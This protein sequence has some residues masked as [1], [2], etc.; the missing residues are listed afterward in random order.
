MGCG[1]SDLQ[2][3]YRVKPTDTS[4]TKSQHL[5]IQV[6]EHVNPICIIQNTNVP[7]DQTTTTTDVQQQLNVFA[8]PV[9]LSPSTALASR[10]LTQTVDSPSIMSNRRNSI[11]TKLG[12]T[13]RDKYIFLQ[14]KSLGRGHFG[15]VRRIQA[16]DTGLLY[17]CKIIEKKDLIKSTSV[18][19]REVSIL[20]TVKD[21]P[22]IV[23]LVD[24]FEDERY[25]Y[26]VM[27]LCDGGDLFSK[28]AQQGKYTEVEAAEA[29]RQLA[30]AIHYIHNAGVVHRDIKP[31]NILLTASGQIKLADF[32]LSKVLRPQQ[33]FQM[34]TLCGT[35][36][37]SAR[38]VILRKPY[39]IKV[40]NWSLGVLMYIL[41]GGYHPFDPYG[42]LEEPELLHRIVNGHFDFRDAVWQNV[43][44]EAKMLIMK[45][46][47]PEPMQ[48]MTLEE[49]LSSRWIVEMGKMSKTQQQQQQHHV[50]QQ[51]QQ[52]DGQ[53]PELNHVQ[54]GLQRYRVAGKQFRILVYTKIASQKFKASLS[55]SATPSNKSN[56][57][58]P[59]DQ[60]TPKEQQ[61]QQHN[62][63]EQQTVQS[64]QLIVGHMHM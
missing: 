1:L 18:V 2:N 49:Y 22:N 53:L 23:S 44:H 41:L 48:R 62:Q 55:R 61:D 60:Q 24:T 56:K 43:S 50:Q 51:L 8:P 47:D 40:D 39:G 17:A 37:Y 15:I 64:S 10:K 58:T 6:Q 63:Q 12:T 13:D 26:L 57:Q 31:E 45:L 46:L 38:E 42:D 4:S 9:S 20:L 33:Q 52:Q 59:K 19:K 16:I 32:G 7:T 30:S 27:E 35:F 25:F 3:R 11:T 28:V 34:R 5:T 54:Q 14:E 36:A 21:H 29:C